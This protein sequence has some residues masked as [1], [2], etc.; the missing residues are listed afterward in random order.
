MKGGVYTGSQYSSVLHPTLK[1]AK[2]LNNILLYCML[3]SISFVKDVCCVCNLCIIHTQ[4]D[5]KTSNITN[6]NNPY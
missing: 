4:L 3:I 6:V 5:R 2:E 1:T